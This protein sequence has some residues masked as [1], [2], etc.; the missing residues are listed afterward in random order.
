[1]AEHVDDR[2]RRVIPRWWP[3]CIAASLGQLDPVGT[4]PREPI[5]PTPLELEELA[6]DWARERNPYHAAGLVDA[7]LVVDRP[8][9]AFEAAEWLIANGG[10]SEV[11]VS[12]ARMVLSPPVGEPSET[13][14]VQTQDERRLS[15]ARIRQNLRKI[16]RN[17]LLWVELAREYS[18]LGQFAATQKA[19]TTAIRLAPNNRFVLRSASRFFLHARDPEFAHA[20]LL[21]SPTTHSDPW[22][23]AAEIVAAQACE[24]SSRLTKLATRHL[25]SGRYDPRHTSELASALGTLEHEAGNRRRV[26]KLFR[27]A[28]IRPTENSVAQ[29]AWVGRHMPGFDLP[30]SSLQTPRAFEARAWEAVVAEDFLR[31]LDWAREWFADEP[32]ATRPALL[33]AW[34]ASTALDDYETA[35]EFINAARIANPHDP[36]LVAQLLY[37]KASADDVGGAEELLP[38]LSRLIDSSETDRSHDEWRVL[39]AADEGLIAYRKGNIE[40]GRCRYREALRIA[41][42]HGLREFRALALMNFWREESLAVP[43]HRPDQH[44]LEQAISAFPPAARGVESCFARRILDI[45]PGDRERA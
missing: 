45:R 13:T 41:E 21:K 26:R 14:H 11:S 29:A 12:L 6:R 17:P 18:A 33:G 9:M 3:L 19:L 23:L 27:H 4:Q 44:A 1:M 7:A 40:L 37:N 38:E 16:P 8:S 42:D 24:E 36:R 43:G 22:L 30:D 28:L 5:V 32:F 35:S 15:V 10:V 39:V 20:I 25:A 34:V 31:A 2:K